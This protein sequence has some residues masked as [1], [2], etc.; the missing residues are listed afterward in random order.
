MGTTIFNAFGY[1]YGVKN[2]ELFHLVSKF[3][4]RDEGFENWFTSHFDWVIC[5]FIFCIEKSFWRV[6]KTI[7]NDYTNAVLFAVLIYGYHLDILEY[8]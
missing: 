4:W 1:F 7:Q 8:R 6:Q 5:G 3:D 2:I